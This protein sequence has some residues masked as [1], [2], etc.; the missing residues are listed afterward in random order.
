MRTM[1]ATQA[2]R[3]FAAL[4]DEAERGETIVITRGGRRVATLGPSTSGNGR[5]VRGLLA[6]ASVDDA[7]G[8]DVMAA[9]DAAESRNVGWPND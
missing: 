6:S 3:A 1:T 9:R 2:S 4:L 7:F 8:D 5:A